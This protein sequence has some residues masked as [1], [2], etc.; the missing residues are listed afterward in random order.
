MMRRRIV[1]LRGVIKGPADVWLGIRMVAWSAAL[2]A[3]KHLL[4]LQLLTRLMWAKPRAAARPDHEPKITFLAQRIYRAR[5]FLRRDNCLERSLLAYRFLAREG[6]E[7]RLVLGARKSE[8]QVLA[9]AWVT[10]A[11]RPLMDGHEALGQFTSLT[12]FGAYGSRADGSLE[13]SPPARTP[14][15][16]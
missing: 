14:G 2:P 10:I 1:N 9:H 12:E 7:P 4:P 6:M 11:G 13:A 15:D 16:P 5:P 3:L 8:G